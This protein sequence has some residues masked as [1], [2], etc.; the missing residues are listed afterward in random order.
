MSIHP[1]AVVDSGA[2]IDP[3][4]EVGAFVTIGPDVRLAEGVEI[5]AHAHVSGRTEISEG[6]VIFSFASIGEE[7]QDLKFNREEQPCLLIGAR[8]MIREYVTIHPGTAE[9]GGT[10]SVGDDNL[11]MIGAHIGHDS[12]IGSHIVISNY[13]QLAGHVTVED[14][15]W[16][17]ANSAVLQFCRV[18]ESAFMSWQTGLMRDLAPYS[19]AIGF[20]ARVRRMNKINLERRGFTPEEIHDVERAFRIIFRS[21]QRPEECFAQVRRELPDSPHAE[22]MIAFLEKSEKGFA[23]L[24]D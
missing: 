5:R 19:W 21:G 3:G 23:R 12:H 20:P 6:S 8:N 7:P 9:G 22:K 24:R 17:S 13:T 14:W 10:T 11:L 2:E 15:A 18:G 1:T 16:L 4:A